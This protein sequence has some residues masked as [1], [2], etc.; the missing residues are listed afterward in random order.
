MKTDISHPEPAA[1]TKTFSMGLTDGIL[2]AVF[3]K[4]S[5]IDI[6]TARE[7]VRTRL[8]FTGDEN[9]PTIIKGG[10]GISFTKEARDFLSS[11]E[12]V[13]GIAAAA[14]IADNFLTSTLAN[15]FLKV[16]V[17]KPKVPTRIFKNEEKALEWLNQYK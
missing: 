3:K 1:E 2:T 7:V 9:Y 15:F 16:T 6:T 11:D 12:G 4:G 14:L 8:R 17:Q 13:Q 10:L 5:T